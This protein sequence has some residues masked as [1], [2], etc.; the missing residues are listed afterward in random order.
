MAN[1]DVQISPRLKG[2]SECI[3]TVKLNAEKNYELI[4]VSI[5]IGQLPLYIVFSSSCT[6]M[7][8]HYFSIIL[9]RSNFS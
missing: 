5:R 2:A 4:Q 3:L 8:E 9:K 1:F 6:I 7:N